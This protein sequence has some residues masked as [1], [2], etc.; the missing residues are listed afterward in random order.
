ME[1]G[2]NALLKGEYPYSAIDHLGGRTSNLPT[3]FFI[4]IPF[5]LMGSAGYLQSFSF[6]AFFLIIL[7][8]FKEYR[9]RLFGLLL[10]VLSPSYIWE[11]Y[12]KSD[13][14]SNFILVLLFLIIIQNRINKNK[15]LNTIITSFGA[16]ALILTRLT[17]IIPIALL[18]FKQFYNLSLKEKTKFLVI[19]LLTSIVFFYICFQ[20][21]GNLEH[22]MRYNPFELQ[23]RY[24]PALISFI[25]ILMSIMYSFKVNDLTS[26]MKLNVLLLLLPIL[27]SFLINV[28][29]NGIFSSIFNSSFDIS[30]FNI[31]MPFLLMVIILDYKILL[32]AINKRINEASA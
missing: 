14:I 30:Y 32:P 12:V 10:L 15:E 28:N 27:I 24:L 17:A 21:V 1:A 7:I 31:I 6:L 13:L 11:I 5:Y 3:L 23:N 26:L 18:L 19:A 9:D 16:T 25:T 4:G 22:F 2:I 8:S 20:R 29:E